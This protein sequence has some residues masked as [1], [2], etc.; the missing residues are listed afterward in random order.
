M[1]IFIFIYKIKSVLSFAP[2]FK[3]WFVPAIKFYT[4]AIGIWG[5]GMPC[6]PFMVNTKHSSF[7]TKCRNSDVRYSQ[8]GLLQ[9]TRSVAH[10]CTEHSAGNTTRFECV[11]SLCLSLR[12]LRSLHALPCATLL[13]LSYQW[14]L[15]DV[16]VWY[17]YLII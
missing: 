16:H 14:V 17:H 2:K 4:R 6:H 5:P 9:N 13:S 15:S 10:V 1:L 3:Y 7:M 11:S 8:L 12:S